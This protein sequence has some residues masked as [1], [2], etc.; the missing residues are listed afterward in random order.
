MN[1]NL[2][3]LSSDSESSDDEF[4]PKTKKSK[5]ND[6]DDDDYDESEKENFMPAAFSHTGQIHDSIKRMIA[7][8]IRY[9]L[10]LSEG[11]AKQSRV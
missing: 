3:I 5:T 1:E 9:K 2:E 7:E 6:S 11:E 8:Q 10:P 4:E